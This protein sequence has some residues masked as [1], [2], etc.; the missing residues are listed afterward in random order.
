[1]E[2]FGLLLV[3]VCV[4]GSTGHW[5]NLGLLRRQGDSVLEESSG[6]WWVHR[7]TSASTATDQSTS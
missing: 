1:M 7:S 4:E 2:R 5:G 6:S 3:G